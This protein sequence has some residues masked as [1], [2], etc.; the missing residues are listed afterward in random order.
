MTPRSLGI[1]LTLCVGLAVSTVARAWVPQELLGRQVVR[2]EVR[3]EAAGLVVPAELGLEPGER[4]S[5]A[6]LRS[7][8]EQLLATG[9]WADVQLDVAPTSGGVVLYVE[10]AARFLL[11]R[12]TVTGNEV[13]D[14]TEVLRALDLHEEEEMDRAFTQTERGRVTLERRLA[15]V[16]QERGYERVHVTFEL[17]DTDE[18]SRKA[19]VVRIDEGTPTRIT[20][21]VFE[22]QAPPPEAHVRRALGIG[23]G[24]IFD[25]REVDEALRSATT[26]LRERRWYSA[27][28]ALAR[29]DRVEGD[30]VLVVESVFGPRYELFIRDAY[31]LSREA[32][33]DVLDLTSERLTPGATQAIAQRVADLYA[34]RGFP[35]TTVHVRRIAGRRAGEARLVV[36][37]DAGRAQRVTDVS[38]PG[39]SHFTQ[40]HLR[41]QLQGFVVDAVDL[42]GLADPLDTR[43]AERLLNS[44]RVSRAGEPRTRPRPLLPR[45]IFYGPAYEQAIEHIQRLYEREGFLNAQVGPLTRVTFARG[46]SDHVEVS[47][48]VVEGPRSYVYEVQLRG[49][50]DLGDREV[51]AAAALARDVPFSHALLDEARARV[52]ALYHDEGYLYARVT[53]GVRFSGDRTRAVVTL[54]VVELYP[55][56]VGEIIIE[57]AERTELSMIRRLVALRTGERFRPSLA[58]R[59]QDRLMELGIFSSVTV[60][61]G[62][63]ELP[64][65]VKPVLVS[66]SERRGQML[67][68]RAG[69]STGQ[70]IRGG[71][72]YGYR[73]LFGKAIGLTL[74]VQ[75][76]NQFFF[77]DSVAADRIRALSLANR[78]ERRITL[79]ILLPY[80]PRL[81]RTRMSLSVSHVRDNQR[82]FGLDSNNVDLTFTTR[83]RR[84]VILTMSGGLENN[85]VDLL[86]DDETY[87]ELLL[88]SPPGLRALLRVP[89]GR[90]TLVSAELGAT[91]DL[92]DNPFNPTRGFYA[93]ASAEWAR[94][95]AA[96]AV[97]VGGM[98]ERFFSHH[99]RTE[100]TLNG[101]VPMGPLTLALQG[102]VGRVFHLEKR[103]ETY[104]NRQ[105]FLGGVDTVRGYL[106][107]SLVP[108]ELADSGVS[109]SQVSAGGDVFMVAR[110]ELRFPIRGMVYGGAFTDFGNLWANGGN[111]NPLQLR[112]TAGFGLRFATPVGPVAFDYGFLLARRRNLDERVGSFHFS[113][114]LF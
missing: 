109:S 54:E 26:T 37:V 90:S 41:E 8:V 69:V 13:L 24:D 35:T 71:F 36:D 15:R 42:G 76:A 30:V 59:T 20:H 108:Q 114:G 40:D 72:E 22:G 68:F 31:P 77:L 86:T 110:A 55:V 43:T 78:L 34:R 63:R 3:G 58:R 28:L 9:R 105:F 33:S 52:E 57:G 95:L 39:A 17:R 1:A 21:I 6:Y 85:D 70:G 80:L 7:T 50:V 5:R 10:L 19:L 82:S 104:P 62:E 83:P 14:D 32:V 66:V 96:E 38:F 65:R 48:P 73:N 107:D 99:V 94:T 112:P 87:Q 49:N 45:E 102:R 93:N 29:I 25:R 44:D 113:I 51:L 100:L 27:Q 47:I 88:N 11:A 91:L 106:Q 16:Y 23:P 103:S 64:A 12:V 18:P 2:I 97:T 46:T 56:T 81:P 4:L 92:R 67:D 75:L 98:S 101:Y 60:E 79:G 74:R 89:Q 84:Q 111:L 61:P 53:P